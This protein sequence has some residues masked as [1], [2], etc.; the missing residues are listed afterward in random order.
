LQKWQLHRHSSQEIQLLLALIVTEVS[1]FQPMKTDKFAFGIAVNH[2]NQPAHSKAT[3]NGQLQFVS[4]HPNP[5]VSLQ[6]HTIVPSKYGI[7]DHPSHFKIF[8]PNRRRCLA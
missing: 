1:S 6:D 2:P 5:S 4:I 7:Q 3:Q 8:K